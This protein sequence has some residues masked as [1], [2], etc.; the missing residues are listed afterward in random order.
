MT[1]VGQIVGLPKGVINLKM[2]PKT[3][4]MD[5]SISMSDPEVPMILK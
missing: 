2:L 1:V 4:T 3:M 5:L